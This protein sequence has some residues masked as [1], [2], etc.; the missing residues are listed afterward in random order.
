M[1]SR[2]T[3]RLERVQ[4]L[5]IP[6]EEQSVSVLFAHVHMLPAT[7]VGEKHEVLVKGYPSQDPNNDCIIGELPG[8]G[9]ELEFDLETKRHTILVRFVGSDGNGRPEGYPP[10]LEGMGREAKT[11]HQTWTG[12]AR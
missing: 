2:L 11:T 7:Y 12:L 5:M 10:E 8:P 9:P 4:Q 6:A 3:K 1:Y